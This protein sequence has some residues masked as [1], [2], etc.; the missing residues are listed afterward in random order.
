MSA[1]S[2]NNDNQEIDLSQ[3]SKKIGSYFERLN[4][5]IFR[6]ILFLKRNILTLSILTAIG[7]GLGQFL[8]ITFKS[9]RNQIIV[10]PSAGGVDYLYSKIDLLSSKLGEKDSIFFKSIGIKNFKKISLISVEPVIDVYN[11]VNN[12][13]TAANAQTT[14]NFELVKLFAENKDINEVIK[15][16]LTS[17]NY[18][19]HSILVTTKGQITK[20]E[21]I[22]PILKYLNTDEYLNKISTI[23]IE[24]IKN[25]LYRSEQEIKQ[26]DS[27]IS[28]T[29][30]SMARNEKSSNLVYNNENNQIN[31]LFG[32]KNNLI[33]E[34]AAQKIELVK[35]E[36]FIKDISI[37]TNIKNSKGINDKLKFI[38]PIL[39]IF[40]FLFA[41][42]FRRF[43]TKQLAKSKI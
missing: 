4:T 1:T 19:F 23:N 36:S 10:S 11:F 20:D 16:K 14:Q 24:N 33:N 38:L 37:T 13:N 26:I 12:S 22:K 9:Y 21:I 43:Y 25:K 35:I 5:K 29:A 7:F 17:R 40:M 27:L 3:I 28:Q 34:I 31:G 8:D 42:L 41:T 18:P 39:F 30:R 6:T 32:L 2:Q 15:D